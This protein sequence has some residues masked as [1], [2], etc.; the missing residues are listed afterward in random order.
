MLLKWK[1]RCYTEYNCGSG[2]EVK[3]KRRRIGQEAMGAG[4]PGMEYRGAVTVRV[5]DRYVR[6]KNTR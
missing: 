3:H 1:E 6:Y 5:L 4:L 2:G